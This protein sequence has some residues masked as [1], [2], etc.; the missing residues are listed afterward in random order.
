MAALVKDVGEEGP[1][2][3]MPV[4]EYTFSRLDQRPVHVP[5]P[6]R[7]SGCYMASSCRWITSPPA[8]VMMCRVC[9]VAG[10]ATG[11]IASGC[12]DGYLRLFDAS[13]AELCSAAAHEGGVAAVVELETA[14][15]S[16]GS[17][18]LTGGQDGAACICRYEDAA[19][20][21]VLRC[22]F[23]PCNESIML[24]K[25]VTNSGTTVVLNHLPRSECPSVYHLVGAV[26]SRYGTVAPV[27]FG[28]R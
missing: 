16:D 27:K 24:S 10:T 13:G 22:A 23:P 4:R 8:D 11:G 3:G 9:A 19:L 21:A 7:F 12:F 25:L 1:C 15:G 14:E 6:A 26:C 17:L 5:P 20:Q 2:D 28:K 18:L